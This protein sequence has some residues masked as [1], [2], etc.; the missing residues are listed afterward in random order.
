MSSELVLAWD[1]LTADTDPDQHLTV[2]TATPGSPTHKRLPRLRLLGRGT[3]PLRVGARAAELTVAVAVARP[4]RRAV[5][6][7]PAA[8]CLHPRRHSVFSRSEHE[9]KP[10]TAAS[11]LSPCQRWVLRIFMAA[12]DTGVPDA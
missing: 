5:A 4:R 10:I 2:S 12:N 7:G 6:V 8:V 11:L 1:T 3:E 9:I